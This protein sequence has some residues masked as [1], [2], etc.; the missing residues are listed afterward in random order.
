VLLCVELL[1]APA[2][3][4]WSEEE[5]TPAADEPV[6]EYELEPLAACELSVLLVVVPFKP[7]SEPLWLY[8]PLLPFL[9]AVSASREA[10]MIAYLVILSLVVRL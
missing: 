1:Y 10:R 9:Q 6:V 4:V 7:V 8:P 5:V 3:E 2:P